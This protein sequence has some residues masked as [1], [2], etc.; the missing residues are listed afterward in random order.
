MTELTHEEKEYLDNKFNEFRANLWAKFKLPA[1]GLAIVFAGFMSVFATYMY[2]SAKADVARAQVDFYQSLLSSQKEI[3]ELKT[4]MI[5]NFND[6]IGDIS[7][8]KESLSALIKE[9]T[10]RQKNTNE[11]KKIGKDVMPGLNFEAKQHEFEQKEYKI[12]PRQ[13]ITK[14]NK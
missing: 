3:T 7:K 12:D 14:E 6:F 11:D 2:T 5:D 13:F 4:E 9:E 10:A 8:Q 1:L